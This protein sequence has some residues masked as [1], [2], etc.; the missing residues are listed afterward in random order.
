MKGNKTEKAEVTHR[1]GESRIKVVI[2]GVGVKLGGGG[3]I[4]GALTSHS[5]RN[6][7]LELGRWVSR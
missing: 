2:G 4:C 7:G 3:H 1:S 6:S 5:L